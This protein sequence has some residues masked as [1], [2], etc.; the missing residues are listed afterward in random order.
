MK[1]NKQ[2]FY[3]EKNAFVDKGDGVI[4]FPDGLVITDDS[5]QWNGTRYDIAS[6]DISDFK[7][8]LTANHSSSIQEMIGQV[9]GTRKIKNQVIIKGIRFAIE[10]NALAK[11]AYNMILGGW[12]TDFSIETV[13][14]WPDDDGIFH[15]SKLVGLSVVV[16]GNN[17][18]ASLNNQEVQQIFANSVKESKQKGLD[19][20]TIEDLF[21]NAIDKKEIIHNNKSMKFVTI[22]NSR[23]FAITLKYKNGNGDD[24]E[25]TVKPGETVDVPEDQKDNVQGQVDGAQAPAAPTPPVEKKEEKKEES[26]DVAEIVKQALAPVT[27]KLVKMEQQIFDNGAK[28]PSFKKANSGTPTSKNVSGELNSLSYKE[29]HGIQINSAWDHLRGGNTEAGRKL[30]TINKFHLEQLQEKGLVEN[31][32]T[33]SDFGNF[34]ISPEL[35]SDIQGFRSNFAPLISKLDFQETLSLQMAWL[36]R[37]GDI[38]MQ[39]VETCDDGADGNLKPISEYGATIETSNL[40]EVAAVTPVCNAATR[41]LAVDLLGDVTK[42]Y[43]TDYDR[44]RAQLFIARLQQAVDSNGN[45]ITYSTTSDVNALKSWVDVIGNVSEEIVNGTF[46]LSNA[47]KWELIK[48]AIGSGISGDILGI[49]KSGDLTPILGGPAIIVPNELLPKLNTAQT[50]AFTVEGSTVTINKAV[51]YVDLANFKG[52]TSGGLKYDLSTEAAYE[53]GND[54]KSAFQRNELVI[55][56]SFFRGGAVLDESQVT[57][58]GSAGV[59]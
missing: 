45:S 9:V 48:R 26:I 11:F 33:I 42:G 5:E 32:V 23:S 8:Q 17:K 13:G 47:S 35:L 6:M 37:T 53:D 41:F 31:S 18:S 1:K 34:V 22:K 46:I 56:G 27:D 50:K 58:L 44:K 24:N 28:E 4:S 55:R 2:L 7:G 52:R 12:L 30:E 15:E 40:K 19:L 21:K 57:A 51:F 39:E 14:P 49:V 36:N 54:V 25:T 59:S 3:I 43:R 16:M 29:R 20:S 38:D 10:E